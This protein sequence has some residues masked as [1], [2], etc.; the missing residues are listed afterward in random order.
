M[1]TSS[2][3]YVP[4]KMWRGSLSL[5][6]FLLSLSE[7]LY[8]RLFNT[9]PSLTPLWSS[10]RPGQSAA[11]VFGSKQLTS[12]SVLLETPYGELKVALLPLF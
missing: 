7:D 9:S 8:I 4:D 6:L 10:C 11:N 5:S 3:I 1:W 12:P 2:Y